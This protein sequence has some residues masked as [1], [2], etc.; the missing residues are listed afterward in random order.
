[1]SE[2]FEEIYKIKNSILDLTINSEK[3]SAAIEKIKPRIF[4]C[5][6]KNMTKLIAIRLLWSRLNKIQNINKNRAPIP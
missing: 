1:M 3:T 4:V 6:N 2:I 5:A